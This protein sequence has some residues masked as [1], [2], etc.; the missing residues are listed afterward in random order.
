MSWSIHM[1][2]SVTRRLATVGMGISILAASVTHAGSAAAEVGSETT[3]VTGK[4]IVGGALVLGEA[5]MLVEAAFG[6]EPWWA[7]ALGGGLGAVGGGVGGYF[8]ADA[9]IASSLPTALLTA[10]LVLAIPTAIAVLHA[11]SSG[12]PA[13][14]KGDGQ[15]AALKKLQ[16]RPPSLVA[17]EDENGWAFS[18]PAVSVGEVY[19]AQL[20]KTYALPSETEVKV[21]LFD[22]QF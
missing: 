5:V 9:D 12:G 4:G 18:M 19:S 11:S 21:P 17:Y 2:K 3:S 1:Q 16:A 6:V 14:L 22:V 15:V 10:G 7:Y 20:R 8:L 13:E